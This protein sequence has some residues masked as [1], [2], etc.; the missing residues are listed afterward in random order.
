MI[1]DLREYTDR[2]L[3]EADVCVI[4][5]GAAGITIAR[6]LTAARL[7]ICLIESGGVEF[8]APVQQLY[9]AEN[10]GRPRRAHTVSRL[11][12]LGGTTNHWTGLCAPLDD[13]DFVATPWAPYSGWPITKAELDPYYARAFA[14]CGLRHSVFDGRLWPLVGRK[15]MPVSARRLTQFFLH[16]SPAVRFGVVYRDELEQDPRLLLLTHANAT[17]LQPTED[18]AHVAHV[19]LRSLEGKS[20]QVRARIYVLACG[21]IENARLL[22]LSDRVT[23]RGLGNRHDVVGRFFMDHPFGKCGEIVQSGHVRLHDLYTDFRHEGAGYRPGFALSPEVRMAEGVLNAGAHLWPAYQAESA[24]TRAARGILAAL[25]SR[26]LPREL[27]RDIQ[28]VIG[29]LDHVVFDVQ[30]RLTGNRGDVDARPRLDLMCALEQSPNPDSRIALSTGRD[31]LGLR[32]ARVDWR[33][34]DLDRRT[35]QV[36]TQTV[37]LEL[38]RLNLGR[39]H[40]PESLRDAQPDWDR[41]LTDY[42]HHMG[43]TRMASDP[44]RGVVDRDCRVHG[45]DNLHV[46]GSS[47]FP[48]AGHVNPTLTIVALALRLADR[49]S[50]LR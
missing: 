40:V 13:E 4:G 27:G 12:F 19:D 31:A 14:I 37:A 30:R 43:A 44:A 49:L 11:R 15:P 38:G 22:L 41:E 42:N 26:S 48:T 10:V 20:A 36:V 5:A 18:G 16:Y 45:V 7:R 3:I 33:L 32:R 9:D 28:K 39:V 29:D 34:T 47:V 50:R 35:L 24:G 6:V 2:S 23:P 25:A 46:A 17:N 8:E 21:G 1:R